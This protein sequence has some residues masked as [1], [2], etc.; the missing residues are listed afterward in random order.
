MILLD[1]NVV[2]EVMRPA[3][4]TGVLRWLGEQRTERV[5]L[6]VVTIAEIHYSL[7]LLTDQPRRRDLRERFQR[8]ADEGFA[9]RVLDFDRHAAERSGAVLAERRRAGR[10]ISVPDAQIA[11][12][13]LTNGLRV[14]TRNTRDFVGVGVDLIDPFAFDR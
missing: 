7:N 2:S 13:A 5:H 1:T 8:F 11:A 4:D 3:P 9:S 12:T 14:A 10:P 6:S